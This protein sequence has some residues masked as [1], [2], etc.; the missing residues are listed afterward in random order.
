M[1]MQDLRDEVAEHLSQQHLQVHTDSINDDETVLVVSKNSLIKTVVRLQRFRHR[2]LEV[3][4]NVDYNDVKT[5]KDVLWTTKPATRRQDRI[6][7]R[8]LWLLPV[9]GGLIIALVTYFESWFAAFFGGDQLD[10]LQL[11]VVVTILSIILA[12]SWIY[13]IP[14]LV[15]Q[16]QQRMQ[17]FDEELLIMI[18]DKIQQLDDQLTTT[19]VVR[20]WSCFGQLE[21]KIEICPHCGEKQ[22]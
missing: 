8:W 22:K 19:P 18:S 13:G 4:I 11:I 7:F 9:F 17:E 6:S 21:P 5:T 3:V 16:R 14:V 20:C 15:K 2:P 10:Q 1:A 12:V